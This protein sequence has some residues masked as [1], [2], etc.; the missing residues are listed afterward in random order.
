L[1]DGLDV[2]CNPGNP[3]LILAEIYSDTGSASGCNW[4]GTVE[5]VEKVL[6]SMWV[7]LTAQ[8]G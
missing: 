3:G 1:L 5:K 2:D 8:P 4:S 6:L 7:W